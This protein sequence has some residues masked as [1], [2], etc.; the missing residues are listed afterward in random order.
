MIFTRALK[1][2]IAAQANE[3]GQLTGI[4]AAIHRSMA[5]IEFRLDGT[6][7]AANDNFVGLM[8]YRLDDIVGRHHR[9]FCEPAYAR[10]ADYVTLW[11]KL[12]RGEP[13]TGRFPRLT[14]DGR[15][16]WLEASYTPVF[17]EGVLV[18]VIKLASDVTSAVQAENE[19][20]SRLDAID[21]SMAQIE[22]T[23][24]GI[25]LTANANF[26]RVMGYRLEQVVGKHHAAFCEADASNGEEYRTFWERL[27]RGEFIS[28]R[29][30]RI[31]SRGA[32]VWLE[33]S[34]NPVFDEAGRV[35]KV[36]KYAADI[37]ERQRRYE[38]ETENARRAFELSQKTLNAADE[39][40]SVIRQA[41]GAMQ[42]I[43]NTIQS[44]A[45]SIEALG[46]QSQRISSI[47][48]TIREIADQTNLLALNAAIEAAR[49]GEQG[50]GFAVVADEVRQL[51]E[52]TARST[53]EIGDMIHS[54][55]ESTDR[56]VV[57]MGSSRKETEA[58]VEH[59]HHAGQVMERISEHSRHVV[60]AVSTFGNGLQ[61]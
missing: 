58:G 37:T 31:D 39:G 22:F 54:V 38:A 47:V 56:A 16:V 50:R 45:E 8:G 27:N 3:L 61:G 17:D 13:V 48:K 42:R 60:D 32:A 19:A 24:Q 28:G 49:A 2:T 43:A 20:A 34:Y 35:Y 59:T 12:A 1:Q 29:F 30:K 5:V 23:P 36:V 25:V 7:V 55:Q 9:Q 41:T 26:L 21:R 52:R 33:A 11:Q 15:R 44:S 4:L 14:R 51:A 10:S 53:S 6:V 46:A 57:A 18:K 40:S